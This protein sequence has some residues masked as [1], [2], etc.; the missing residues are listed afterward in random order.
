MVP[1]ES[2]QEYDW[3]KQIRTTLASSISQNN[4]KLAKVTD[5][6]MLLMY[7]LCDHTTILQPHK[8]NDIPCSIKWDLIALRKKMKSTS[9]ADIG[10]NEVNV[11]ELFATPIKLQKFRRTTLKMKPKIYE[12]IKEKQHSG[13]NSQFSG[14]GVELNDN[15]E[16][17]HIPFSSL[18]DERAI[19]IVN[20]S[21][22]DIIVMLVKENW[23]AWSI[24]RQWEGKY[25][26]LQFSWELRER[27]IV[28]LEDKLFNQSS[29]PNMNTEIKKCMEQKDEEIKRLT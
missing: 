7:W 25:K 19:V 8:P 14:D 18:H 12:N 2:M 16:D 24:I 1:L 22:P 17:I 21:Q 9:L 26:H 28:D 13:S 3:A 11:G 6:V 5:C 29:P 20:T 4:K 23:K 10:F 27:V 15:N